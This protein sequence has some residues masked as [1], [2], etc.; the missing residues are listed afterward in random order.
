MTRPAF[1]FWMC[2][3]Y[4]KKVAMGRTL[5]PVKDQTMNATTVP[6]C[7]TL[8][9]KIGQELAKHVL[10]R[11]FSVGGPMWNGLM[12]QHLKLA[13]PIGVEPITF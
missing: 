8:D 10:H 2:G 3:S 11:F 4:T 5:L 6:E 12:L 13:H 9:V 1:C 7:Q